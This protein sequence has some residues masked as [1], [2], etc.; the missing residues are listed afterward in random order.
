MRADPRHQ[1]A[2]RLAPGK[3]PASAPRCGAASCALRRGAREAPRP[4]RSCRGMCGGLGRR[5]CREPNGS[6]HL[7]RPSPIAAIRGGRTS[8]QSRY[9]SISRLV[10]AESLVGYA[11]ERFIKNSRRSPRHKRLYVSRREWLF[12]FDEGPFPSKGLG[13][14]GAA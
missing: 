13:T 4:T 8:A 1:G 7:V 3:A 12:G 6:L 2:G 14:S 11:A 10:F 5:Q 9:R